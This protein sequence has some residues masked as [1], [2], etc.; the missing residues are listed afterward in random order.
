VKLICIDPGYDKSGW[1]FFPKA[2]VGKKLK[3]ELPTEWGTVVGKGQFEERMTSIHDQFV[4]LVKKLKMEKAIIEWPSYEMSPRGHAA[5]VKDDLGKI[6]SA[7]AS[8]VLA[9]LGN[10][11]EIERV[12]V[13]EWK[14]QLP[15][16][17]VWNRAK[18]VMGD[19]KWSQFKN[20]HIRDAVAL[21]LWDI[22]RRVV[23]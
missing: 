21:G 12:R 20:E 7:S 18:K 19:D 22:K 11:V 4:E 2:N 6:I 13:R 8:I 23:K 14:G 16:K 9:C 17:V 3:I 5:A 10:G 15:K 1:A